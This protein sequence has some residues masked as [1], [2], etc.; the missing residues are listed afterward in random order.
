MHIH[1]CVCVCG[2]MGA[3]VHVFVQMVKTIVFKMIGFQKKL[4]GQNTKII[5]W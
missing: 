1:M 3:Y 2:W 5:D 4:T